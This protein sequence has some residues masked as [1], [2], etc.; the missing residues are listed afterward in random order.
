MVPHLVYQLLS[1]I[2]T[3]RKAI[4]PANAGVLFIHAVE[5]PCKFLRIFIY[6]SF[7]LD[8]LSD[9]KAPSQRRRRKYEKVIFFLQEVEVKAQ[10]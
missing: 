6:A 9:I 10:K 4:G 7:F 5:I 1:W 8:N 3:E 2:I